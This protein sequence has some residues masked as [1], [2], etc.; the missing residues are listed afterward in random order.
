[1]GVAATVLAFL[2]AFAVAVWW[3]QLDERIK[4]QVND[5][6]IKDL[7]PK[8]E[9]Q[10]NEI[11]LKFNQ[12]KIVLQGGI[13]EVE[14]NLKKFAR[15]QEETI[16]NIEFSSRALLYLVMGNRLLE[17]K[18]T[19][20]L[21]SYFRKLNNFS[22]MMHKSTI[23]SVKPTDQLDRM[24]RLL[25]ALRQQLTLRKISLRRILNLEWLIAIKQISYIL[26]RH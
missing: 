9:E 24:M 11:T 18:K 13:T 2:G 7:T 1:M 10:I 25:F 17:Q 23:Y 6:Y 22:Q 16:K 8:I 14:N 3:N 21:L 26:T 4:K 19:G 12:T 5:T 15:V 20:L